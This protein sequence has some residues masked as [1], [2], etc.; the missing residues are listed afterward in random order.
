[1]ITVNTFSISTDRTS[2]ALEVTVDPGQVVN[3][4]KLWT[5]STYKIESQAVDLNSLISGA[6]NTESITINASD[7]PGV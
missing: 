4:L 7:V 5:E 3:D 1:M 6:S 2:I